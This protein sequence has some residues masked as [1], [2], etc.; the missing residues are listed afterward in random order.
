MV[1]AHVL[2]DT[3]VLTVA[4]VNKDTTNQLMAHVNVGLVLSEHE[5]MSK[6]IFFTAS[7]IHNIIHL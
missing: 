3:P 4:I 1:C 6:T 2:L 7:I 5:K